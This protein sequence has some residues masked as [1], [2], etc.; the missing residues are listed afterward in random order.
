MIITFNLVIS[1]LCNSK[2]TILH[3]TIPS[4]TWFTDEGKKN[5]QAPPL[6]VS[7]NPIR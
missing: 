7:S 2:P 3:C 5:Q 6:F 1:D 4:P